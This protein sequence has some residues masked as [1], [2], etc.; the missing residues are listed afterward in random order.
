[1]KQDFT[2]CL[3]L[4]ATWAPLISAVGTLIVAIAVAFIAYRQWRVAH[5]KLI[6]DLFDKRFAVYSEAREAVRTYWTPTAPTSEM[7]IPFDRETYGRRMARIA[8]LHDVGRRAEFL[9]GDEVAARIK[10]VRDALI[11]GTPSTP[12]EVEDDEARRRSEE[13]Y[14]RAHKE[15]AAFPKDLDRLVSKYMRITRAL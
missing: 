15:A 2:G 6:L 1:M 9:F 3:S 13:A 12:L 11:E 8:T 5:E 14:K 4:I 7:T 10:I